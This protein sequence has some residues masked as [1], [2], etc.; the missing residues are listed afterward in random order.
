MIPCR[1]EE[2]LNRKYPCYRAPI[3]RSAAQDEPA[4]GQEL[5]N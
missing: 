4:K 2:T 3:R 1:L 5:D